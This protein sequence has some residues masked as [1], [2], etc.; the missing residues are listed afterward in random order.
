MEIKKKKYIIKENYKISKD[1][2]NED[3][4]ENTLLLAGFVPVIGEIADLISIYRYIKQE[5]YIEAGLMIF[6]LIPTVGDIITKPIIKLIGSSRGLMKS[7]ELLVK[8]LESNPI[9]KKKFLE[10]GKHIND[11]KINKLI[12]QVTDKA[13]SLGK[14]LSKSKNII[15][16]ILNN[17]EKGI[18]TAFKD[19]FKAKATAKYV[20]K[21]GKLPK[22]KLSH[23]FNIIRPA[24][25]ERRMFINNIIKTNNLLGYLGIYNIEDLD[26]A[27]NDPKKSEQLVNDPNFQKLVDQVTT[28]EEMA[29]LK[30]DTID[31]PQNNIE[32]ILSTDMVKNI[33]LGG[34]KMLAKF[35]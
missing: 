4:I 21:Y 9:A 22:S 7:P 31:E 34:F 23:W 24:K 2:L 3:W 5:R 17:L 27:I 35:I 33:G 11:P 20:S 29:Q 30:N 25:R 19:A 16:S 13:P 26:K 12:T 6:A 15:S 32:N 1:Q 10:L 18:G 14:E 28:P 8:A